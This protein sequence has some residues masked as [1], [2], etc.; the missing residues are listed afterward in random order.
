MHQ[1][2]KGPGNAPLIVTGSWDKTVKYR[3]LRQDQPLATVNVKDKV[4]SMDAQ[5]KELM[6][7][8]AGSNF[9]AIDLD[10]P[11]TIYEHPLVTGNKGEIRAVKCFPDL[12]GFVAAATGAEAAVYW[13]GSYNIA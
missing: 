8:T 3:D 2:L 9:C 13:L 6:V 10:N 11:T 5:E 7:A 4:Y 1:S 12:K